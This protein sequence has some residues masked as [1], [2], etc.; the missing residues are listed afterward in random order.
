MGWMY[1]KSSSLFET[2]HDVPELRRT[3]T[4]SEVSWWDSAKVLSIAKA[5]TIAQDASAM[6]GGST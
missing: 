3:M 4:S 6:A 1:S 5:K 2:A